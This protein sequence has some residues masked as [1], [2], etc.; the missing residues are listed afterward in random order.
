MKKLPNK[1]KNNE[2]SLFIKGLRKIATLSLDQDE[3]MLVR[4]WCEKYK[5]PPNHPLLLGRYTEDLMVEALQDQHIRDQ[6]DKKDKKEESQDE[7]WEKDLSS[8]HDE[9]I[10]KKLASI[11]NAPQNTLEKWQKKAKLIEGE[12]NITND[13]DELEIDEEF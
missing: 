4:W 2:D 8:E 13:I 7:G 6:Q 12:E 9:K 10:K 5:L 1:E 3:G 11:K